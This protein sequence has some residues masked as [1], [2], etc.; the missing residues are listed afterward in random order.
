MSAVQLRK[1]L[2]N[3]DNNK[4]LNL[5]AFRKL[6]ESLNLNHRFTLSDIQAKRD[7]GQRYFVTSINPSLLEN[8]RQYAGHISS[9]RISA[10]CENNSHNHK[11][12]GS[13]LLV[14][15]SPL[16]TT[17]EKHHPIVLLFDDHGNT[18]Y[19]TPDLAKNRAKNALL[20]ENRQLLIKWQQTTDFLRAH[21]DFNCLDYDIIFGA[22]NEISNSFHKP[23]LSQ[24][25][26]LYFCFDIDL[27]GVAIAK[28][29]INLLPTV[30]YEFVMP[31]DIDDRLSRVTRLMNAAAVNEVKNHA[32]GHAGLT[33][34]SNVIGTHFKRIEQESFLYE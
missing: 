8:L 20:I 7:K 34:V 3:F 18:T 24:Y 13:Y 27:G 16:S 11:V 4:S 12:I 9:D 1:Y 19:P 26:K 30:P 5:I 6:V 2:E 17:P 31:A 28:N 21:C 10:A 29:L 25:Q 14:I 15:Q 23:Y 32:K 22:G 33:K